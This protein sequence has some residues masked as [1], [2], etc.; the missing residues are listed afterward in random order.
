MGDKHKAKAGRIIRQEQE[1]RINQ[2]EDKLA[3]EKVKRNDV[4]L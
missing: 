2:L 3:W 1:T 4:I